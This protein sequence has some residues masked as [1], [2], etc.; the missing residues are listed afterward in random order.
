MIYNGS[1]IIGYELNRIKNYIRGAP[2]SRCKSSHF[3]L[4]EVLS[5]DTCLDQKITMMDEILGH[6]W[7]I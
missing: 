6:G 4:P 3:L 1:V 7:L 5:D 2:F